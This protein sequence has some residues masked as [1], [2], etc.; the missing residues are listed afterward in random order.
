MAFCE[1]L[2]RLSPVAGPRCAECDAC[3]MRE[4]ADTS[5]PAIFECWNGLYDCAIPI[6]PKGHVLGYFL[7]GQILTRQPDPERY[8]RTAVEIGADPDEYV[9]ALWPT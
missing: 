7:C 1:D 6:A 5:Q 3:G 9:E 8:R 2:T 4:A